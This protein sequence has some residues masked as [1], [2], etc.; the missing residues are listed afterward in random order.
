MKQKLDDLKLLLQ[1]DKK[2]Q[3]MAIIVV[4]L[5]A[6]FFI[7]DSTSR[8]AGRRVED[9]TP[10]SVGNEEDEV[11]SDLITRFETELTSVKKDVEHSQ[12]QTEQIIT[13]LETYEE[14]TAEIFKK[15]LE[16]IA[17]TEHGPSQGIIP[18]SPLG[19]GPTNVSGTPVVAFDDDGDGIPDGFDIDG[20]GIPDGTPMDTDGDGIYDALDLN[21]D[22][23]PDGKLIDTDGDG[24]PDLFEPFEQKNPFDGAIVIHLDNDGMPDGVDTIGDG[25]ID[26][27]FVDVDGDGI[28]DEIDRD[29]DGVTDGRLFDLDGDSV[30]DALELDG[31]GRPDVRMVDTDGDGLLDRT[32]LINN[33]AVNVSAA[34]VE[35]GGMN[36]NTLTP[37]WDD[38]KP[39]EPPAVEPAPAKTVFVAAG[40][41]VRVKLLAG[42]N[43]PT[44]D[45]PYPVM[46][47]MI[48]SVDGPDGS[49]LPLGE[50]RVIAAAQGSLSDSR[51]LFRLSQLSLRFPTGERKVLDI[52]GWVVG[53]DGI[54]GLQ[55]IPVD[56]IGRVLTGH[57]LAGT[58]GGMG[59]AFRGRNVTTTSNG[60]FTSTQVTGDAVEYGLGTGVSRA[61]DKW[62]EYISE[63][64]EARPPVIKIFSGREAT[65][66]FSKSFE[67][68]GLM[69][70]L[71]QE[72][73]K[74]ASLD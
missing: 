47:K 18:D 26:V 70:A 29:S 33:P 43:A 12:K 44:D 25:K 35:A 52:D 53:E 54:R 56:P 49:S 65:A 24:I 67:I 51:V 59:Q 30:P 62:S 46:F 32:E 22:G 14:R 17:D 41:T 9:N 68:E 15:I 38:V 19:G 48:S 39:V 55:G 7:L 37:M 16:K 20:D 3:S 45:R 4:G 31:D 69:E 71:E 34:G 63:Q 6:M 60:M 58:V 74:Y 57:V 8:P 36:D 5:I 72:D 2:T 1:K 13:K 11:Y 10:V 64:A 23:I 27:Q 66:V 28:P 50:G 42:V 21:N 73:V 61:T 40:D